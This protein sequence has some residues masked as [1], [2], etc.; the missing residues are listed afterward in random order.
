MKIIFAFILNACILS[1]AS[2]NPIDNEIDKFFDGVAGDI[3]KTVDKE[4]KALVDGIEKEGRALVKDVDT[5]IKKVSKENQLDVQ[6]SERLS[7][8]IATT[9]ES[10][11]SLELSSK[12]KSLKLVR[13]DYVATE[14]TLGEVLGKLHKSNVVNFKDYSL[15]EIKGVKILTLNFVPSFQDEGTIKVIFV[16][17]NEVSILAKIMT[18]EGNQSGSLEDSDAQVALMGLMR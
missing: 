4:A 17:K 15:K 1:L 12:E 14:W 11:N 6:K 9:K 3:E 18:S 2:A 8:D 13:S 7:R 10:L 5:N 16:I